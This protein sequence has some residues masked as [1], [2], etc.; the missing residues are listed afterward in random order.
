MA[1]C[2][3]DTMLGRARKD[4]YAVGAFNIVALELLPTILLAAEEEQSP[5]ILAVAPIHFNLMDMHEYI[6]Y[7]KSLIQKTSVPVALHLDHGKNLET[8]IQGIQFGFPSLMFD[9]SRLP[10]DENVALT[11]NVVWMCKQINVTVEAELGTLNDEG[12]DLTKETRTKLFTDPDAAQKFV[13]ATGV[14]ALA[15]SIGNAHGVYKGEPQLDFDRLKSIR[16][17]VPVPLVLHGGS[18]ISDADFKKAISQGINKI[19]IFTEMNHSASA[20]A[21]TIL[22]AQESPADYPS[23]LAQIREVVK[24]V[25]KKKMQVFGS[26]GK[27]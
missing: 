20:E 13:T 21:K 11:K 9:G 4:N 8:V 18:G 6:V 3:L 2:S 23:T 15:V 22:N 27:A 24:K 12:L 10:F 14:D 7:V 5:V 17:K 26:A 16:D 1:L 19:N 25:V